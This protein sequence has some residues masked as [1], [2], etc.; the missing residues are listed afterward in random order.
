MQVLPV[1][2]RCPRVWAAV[3]IASTLA[4][5][6]VALSRVSRVA[7]ALRPYFRSVHALAGIGL[8][9]A[10][11]GVPVFGFY[12]DAVGY[13][14][15]RESDFAS[16][17][18]HHA[19]RDRGNNLKEYCQ[20]LRDSARL[21]GECR[22]PHRGMTKISRACTRRRRVPPTQSRRPAITAPR[23]RLPIVQRSC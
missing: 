3:K 1:Q 14:L 10:V 2:M 8:F 5:V 20:T 19:L 12:Q 16:A 18:T 13:Y 9:T 23:N 15:S 21:D 4:G 6:I 11:A 7:R 22:Q 17:W